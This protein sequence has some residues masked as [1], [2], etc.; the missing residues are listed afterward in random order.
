MGGAMGGLV[1]VWLWC[2][3]WGEK[4]EVIHLKGV[5]YILHLSSSNLEG[6]IMNMF[7]LTY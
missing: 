1:A 5:L 4:K 7:N 3:G 6:C 2:G